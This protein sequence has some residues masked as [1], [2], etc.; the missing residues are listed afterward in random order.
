MTNEDSGD[1]PHHQI[2]A[3][4]NWEFMPGWTVTPAVNYVI[5]RDRPPMDTRDE[6][7][8]YMVVDLTL[9]SQAFSDQ[10]EL[11]A[12]VRN[13]FNSSPEEP[14]EAGLNISNDL[15]LER[16]TIFAEFRVNFH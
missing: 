2:Y 13:L 6:L 14:T 9:R 16:R 11:A 8:D 5:E 12:G 7:D 10:W 3:R 4:A 1:A 15:P